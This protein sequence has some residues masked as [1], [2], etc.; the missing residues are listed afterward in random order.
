MSNSPLLTKEE[1][2]TESGDGRSSHTIYGFS[3]VAGI[4]NPIESYSPAPAVESVIDQRPFNYLNAEDH[5]GELH[6]SPGVNISEHDAVDYVSGSKLHGRNAMID[7]VS[8]DMTSSTSSEVGEKLIDVHFLFTLGDVAENDA[9]KYLDLKINVTQNYEHTPSGIWPPPQ[10]SAQTSHQLYEH[11]VPGGK[12][13][14]EVAVRMSIKNVVEFMKTQ[15]RFHLF[16]T[17]EENSD[18]IAQ[19]RDAGTFIQWSKMEACVFVSFLETKQ[20]L[21][22]INCD[23][24]RSLFMGHLSTNS[25]DFFLGSFDFDEER[26]YHVNPSEAALKGSGESSLPPAMSGQGLAGDGRV[27]V[28]DEEDRVYEARKARAGRPYHK[29][30][31]AML[32][33][34]AQVEKVFEIR[35]RWH[36]LTARQ[37]KDHISGPDFYSFFTLNRDEAAGILPVCSTWFKDVLRLHGVKVWPGRP[38][39]RSGALLEALKMQLRSEEAALQFT[40][41]NTEEENERQHK[42]YSLKRDIERVIEERVAIVKKN[43]TPSYFAQYE[44]LQGKQYL[45][46]IWAAL[47]P[48]IPDSSS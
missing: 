44:L 45:D 47:P 30:T 18:A 7:N 28:V 6:T 10:N 5:C 41:S 27:V 1:R 12:H 2:E 13:L 34:R 26:L 31:K 9:W 3:G 40:N 19:L 24:V 23:I 20:Y 42:I 39:R 21:R 36:N 4:L 46:P 29:N 17:V 37:R 35:Q 11:A 38:L 15:Y 32:M 8:R 22:P 48:P 25:L 33:T 43:V 16:C 14:K